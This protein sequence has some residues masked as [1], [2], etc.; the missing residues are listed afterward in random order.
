MRHR[1]RKNRKIS[2]TTLLSALTIVSHVAA[3]AGAIVVLLDTLH[4]W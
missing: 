1:P 4:H 3:V 2:R